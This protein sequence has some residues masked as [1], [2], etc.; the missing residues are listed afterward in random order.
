MA[1]IV[2]PLL[3][4]LTVILLSLVLLPCF[5]QAGAEEGE[6]RSFIFM[7]EDALTNPDKLL[8]L[9]HGAGVV[10]AGQ[11]SR[12]YAYCRVPDGRGLHRSPPDLYGQRQDTVPKP[13]SPHKGGLF[14][15]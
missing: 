11:W 6:A 7:T 3:N 2:D 10:R 13:F 8:I 1:D 15:H 5:Y 9:I 12:R 14:L 4:L